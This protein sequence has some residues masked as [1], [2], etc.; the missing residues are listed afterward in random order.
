MYSKFRLPI[1]YESQIAS[2]IQR[3]RLNILVH[4][5]LYYELNDNMI[6]DKQFDGACRELVELQKN[7]PEIASQVI[8]ADAFQNFDGTTGF[9]LPYND[10][11]VVNK[12]EQLRKY[13]GERPND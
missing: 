4:S 5:R 2:R 11:W 13:R 8:Y 10:E 3:L 9:D 12:V 7:Y 6:S 1:I